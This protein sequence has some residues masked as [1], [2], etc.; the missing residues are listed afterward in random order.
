[1][2]LFSFVD[3]LSRGESRRE[4]Q[5]VRAD[6]QPSVPVLARREARKMAKWANPPLTAALGARQAIDNAR[7]SQARSGKRA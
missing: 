5:G 3:F 2:L 4:R 6:M 7:F 1:M